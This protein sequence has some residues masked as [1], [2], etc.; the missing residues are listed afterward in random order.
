MNE[1][2]FKMPE[3]PKIRQYKCKRINRKK[4]PKIKT[5][6]KKINAHSFTHGM[7]AN[8]YNSCLRKKTK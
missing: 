8:L 1:I 5:L 2:I 6:N 3:L 7:L 4:P